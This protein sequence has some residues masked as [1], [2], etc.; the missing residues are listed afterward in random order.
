MLSTV[1]GF[2]GIFEILAHLR[3]RSNRGKRR[4]AL[5][6]GWGRPVTR[7]W[8]FGQYP[9]CLSYRSL[10]GQPNYIDG[11]TWSDLN[12]DA[13]FAAQDRT[14]TSPGEIEL[15]NA[16]STLARAEAISPAAASAGASALSRS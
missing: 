4:R 7:R 16:S 2:P 5:H 12:L 6:D 3:D 14:I 13:V 8:D 10:A 9:A 1:L 15:C 11:Q